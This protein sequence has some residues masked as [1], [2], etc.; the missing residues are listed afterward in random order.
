MPKQEAGEE[1]GPG[2]A[3]RP[4]I[5]GPNAYG[6]HRKV[7]ERG[8]DIKARLRGQGQGDREEHRAGGSLHRLPGHF[9]CRS[10]TC[11]AA[12]CSCRPLTPGAHYGQD[13]TEALLTY[14]PSKP[15]ETEDKMERIFALFKMKYSGKQ[16]GPHCPFTASSPDLLPR[17]RTSQGPQAAHAPGPMGQRAEES[18]ARP[19]SAAPCRS[20]NVTLASGRLLPFWKITTFI[21]ENERIPT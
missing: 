12:S 7:P 4:V 10:W 21:H 11:A 14:R 18:A 3:Q 5:R 19:P 8:A 20:G 2:A 1:Q 13:P 9:S 15:P 17:G 16:P 6:F